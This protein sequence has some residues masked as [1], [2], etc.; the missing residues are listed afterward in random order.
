MPKALLGDAVLADSDKYEMVEGNV[1]F[2]PDSVNWD[3]FKPGDRKY[4]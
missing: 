4:T 1:Y 3:Y 2:P